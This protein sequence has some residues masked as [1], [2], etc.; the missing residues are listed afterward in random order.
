ML[1][2]PNYNV[3]PGRN[4]GITG[5][6]RKRRRKNY[7]TEISSLQQLFQEGTCSEIFF[8]IKCHRF[9]RLSR[10]LPLIWGREGSGCKTPEAREKEKYTLLISIT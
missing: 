6:R 1:C 5:V 8:W 9:W 10:A 4:K 2:N 7:F 3:F